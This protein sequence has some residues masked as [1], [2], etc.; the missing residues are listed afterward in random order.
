MAAKKTKMK[1]KGLRYKTITLKVTSRQKRSLINFCKA[2]RT[3]PN[4]IIKKAIRPLLQNYTNLE[5][6]VHAE[7][8]NQLELFE[9]EIK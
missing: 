1:R 7:K 2:R 8:V 3:T 5:V 4:K 6:T 9:L